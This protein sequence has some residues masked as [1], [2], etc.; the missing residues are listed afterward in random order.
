MRSGKDCV[1]EVCV[2]QSEVTEYEMRS[3]IS[4]IHLMLEVAVFSA[5]IS[6]AGRWEKALHGA[7]IT[8]S[9]LNLGI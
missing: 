4:N 1:K 3:E 6:F 9:Q 2:M 7:R 8:A 5:A